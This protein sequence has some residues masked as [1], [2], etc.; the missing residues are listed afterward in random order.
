[1]ENLL[2]RLL[3]VEHEHLIRMGNARGTALAD[4]VR[5]CAFHLNVFRFGPHSLL[6]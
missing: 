3:A 1:M 4:R 2:N 6:R 5:F